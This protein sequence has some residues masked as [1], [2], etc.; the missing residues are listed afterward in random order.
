MAMQER[1][2]KKNPVFLLSQTYSEDLV[3]ALCCCS[4]IYRGL[5][6]KEDQHVCADLGARD[7]HVGENPQSKAQTVQTLRS[8]S[9]YMWHFIAVMW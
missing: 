4:E 2:G 8:A 7:Q 3:P 9:E 1:D 6:E 5:W